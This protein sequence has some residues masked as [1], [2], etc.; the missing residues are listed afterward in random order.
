MQGIICLMTLISIAL[1]VM[2]YAKGFLD[3][4]DAHDEEMKTR[5]RK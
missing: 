3:G 1:C 2:A 4:W 5:W